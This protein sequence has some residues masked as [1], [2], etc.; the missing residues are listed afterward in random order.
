MSGT[1]LHPDVIALLFERRAEAARL[2]PWT[3]RSYRPGKRLS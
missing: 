1:T 3:E 2:G